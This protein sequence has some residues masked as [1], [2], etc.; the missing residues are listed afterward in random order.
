[1]ACNSIAI[2]ILMLCFFTRINFPKVI[3]PLGYCI[4]AV[5]LLAAYVFLD[6]P[7]VCGY[8]PRRAAGEVM[9]ESLT[10]W[11]IF[12]LLMPR[13]IVLALRHWREWA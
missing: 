11:L 5:I 10:D 3:P 8:N 6:A 1:M 12:L 4:L 9:R 7:A 13:A 2:N